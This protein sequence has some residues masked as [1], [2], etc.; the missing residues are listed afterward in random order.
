VA[1][2]LTG[3]VPCI[4]AYLVAW[5]IMPEEPRLLPAAPTGQQV[6]SP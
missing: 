3:F 4:V 1:T 6:T 5:I 2:V